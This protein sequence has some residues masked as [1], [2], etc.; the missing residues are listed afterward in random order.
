MSINIYLRAFEY[1]D[2]SFINKIRNDNELFEYTLGNK[3][4]ISSVWDKNWI[5][6]KI[7]NNSNQL[8]LMICSAELNEPIGYGAVTNIDYVNRKAE[9]GG[10]LIAKEFASKGYATQASK[11]FIGHL[12]EE[13]GLNM[14]YTFIREDHIISLRLAENLGLKK[15][16]LLPDYV[17]KRN[18]FHNAYILT[19][20]RSDYEK[21]KG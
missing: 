11:L 20:L 10:I 9:L 8:Y 2:L 7:L 15:Q 13:L 3:Y 4:Y 14:L 1:D 12:F 16:G 21:N 6:D 5:E 19:L 17:Y 18:K